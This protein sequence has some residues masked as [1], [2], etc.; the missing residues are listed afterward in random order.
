MNWHRR[1]TCKILDRPDI[2]PSLMEIVGTLNSRP[3]WG[4][5]AESVILKDVTWTIEGDCLQVDLYISDEF[6]RLPMPIAPGIIVTCIGTPYASKDW[7]S[8]EAAVLV[9]EEADTPVVVNS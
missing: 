4:H 8:I 6:L 2:R 9:P 3:I 1:I 7:S 5:A